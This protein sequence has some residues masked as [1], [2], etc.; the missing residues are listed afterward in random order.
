MGLRIVNAAIAVPP[1]V[2]T[3]TDLAEETSK[4]ISWIERHTGVLRRHVA[5][6]T[7]QVPSL[8]AEAARLALA[9]GGPPDLILNA[10]ASQHQ[11]LPDTSVF[12][13]R[14]LG[15]TGI[16]SYS[17]HATCISFM[18][19]LQVADAL[20]AVGG[21]RRILVCS[22]E[23]ASRSRNYQEPESAALLGDGAAAAVLQWDDSSAGLQRFSMKVS[24]EHIELS[25]VRG[26][27]L[28]RHPRDPDTSPEDYLFRMQGRDVYRSTQPRLIQ[29]IEQVLGDANL[30]IGDIDL[31]VPHQASVA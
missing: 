27:G 30:T 15:L 14:E 20:L 5:D 31:V 6:P 10:S 11:L 2:E 18:M 19:S 22:A 23:L 9:D 7:L 8:A 21:Y 16:A 24:P 12:I 26:G 29:M 28:R 4:S 1:A 25:E 3:A 17:I 13:Q